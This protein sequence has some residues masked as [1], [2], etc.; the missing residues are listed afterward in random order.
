MDALCAMEGAA[1]PESIIIKPAIARAYENF[2]RSE[3]VLFF[4]APCGFG[5]TAVAEALCMGEK[6]LSLSAA[7]PDFALPETAD[8]WSTLLID[9]L[10]QQ[11]DAFW[12]TLCDYIRAPVRS[13]SCSR[14]AHRRAS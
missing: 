1:L 2:W 11:D 4:S 9:D 8:D 13:S 3:R 7:A 14:A 6:V 5:K 10:Q 12:R